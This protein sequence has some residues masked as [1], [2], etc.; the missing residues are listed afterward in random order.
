MSSSRAG[1]GAVADRGQVDDHRDVLVAPAGVPPDVLIDADDLHAVEPGRVLDQQPLALGQD[2]VVGGAPRH[3]EPLGDPRHRQVG[4]HQPFQR[5][6]Q[7]SP[8]QLGP[9]LG[10]LAGVLAPHVRTAGA[11]VA[12]DRD[13]QR[14]RP[15]AQRLVRQP[16]GHRVPGHAPG[17]RSAG[18][19]D[20]ARPPGTP[21]PPDPE[22]SRWPVTS[23]PSSSRRAN[24]VRS[25]Q[26]KRSVRHVEVFLTGRC[27]NSHH[28]KTSTPTQ[29]AT[30]P[31]RLHPALRRATLVAP[32]GDA[33]RVEEVPDP[34][35]PE[36]ASRR[37]Y[38]A[39][40]KAAI[41]AEYDGLD[42]DGRGALLR[43]E[44]LYTSLISEWRK[45]AS[46]GALEAL[47]KARGRPP[48]DPV[49]RENARLKAQ[50]AKLAGRARHVSA[51]DRGAGKALRAAGTARHWQRDRR[52]P[53]EVSALITDAIDE[54][55]VG[56]VPLVGAKA[57][58]EAVGLPRASYYRARPSPAT[59][60]TT[61]GLQRR[62][63]RLGLTTTSQRRR[64]LR[65][66][67]HAPALVRA[68]QAQPRALTE[69]EQ[70]GACWTCC[71]RERFV[72]T[73]PAE[74]LRDAARRGHLPVLGAHDV[75]AAACTRGRPA[76]GAGTPPTRR[77]S[78]PNWSPTQ[79][80]QV[81]S[82]GHHQAARPGE[83]DLLLP[84]RDPGHLLPLRRSAG[85]SPPASRRSWP[86]G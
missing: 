58:C 25:G 54:A 86:S 5:P 48:A 2:R 79:P 26:A 39:K 64:R 62:V 37:T 52:G 8:G 30:R 10:R 69:A 45:Q 1:P 34:Q 31:T 38:T 11:P 85:W 32:V 16:P 50:V 13:Q 33:V 83:V 72:D 6:A 23:K 49:E 74:R 29:A 56:L 71:T 12:A 84:V 61:R 57:A 22:S 3:P 73:A 21:A 15:P 47:G 4:D 81:W 44:G 68:R 46:K 75:P 60:P 66:P 59:R 63:A 43:R 78:S 35:V 36:R 14:R 7:P 19:T 41:L 42:R 28:R 80:N 82:L 53:G 67:D 24:V 65:E 70:R 9:R 17:S 27:E 51:G 55:V 76:T 77:T 20:Q 40:Y 18:T